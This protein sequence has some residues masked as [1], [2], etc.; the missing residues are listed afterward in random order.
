MYDLYSKLHVLAKHKIILTLSSY[1]DKGV[2]TLLF[3][4]DLNRDYT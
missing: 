3:P 4:A 1:T 2:N